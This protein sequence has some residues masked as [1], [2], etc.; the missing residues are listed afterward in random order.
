MKI[1]TYLEFKDNAKAVMETYQAIFNAEVVLEYLYDAEMTDDPAMVG[2]VFHAELE[3]GDQNLYLCDSGVEPAFPSTKLV[4]ETEDEG[5]AKEIFTKLAK[6]GKV[7]REF[8]KMSFGPTIADVEDKFGIKW[9]I[10][11]C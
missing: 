2:K 9:N 1:A 11:I 7:I 6:G 10:V 4:V 8:T 3:M 5:K